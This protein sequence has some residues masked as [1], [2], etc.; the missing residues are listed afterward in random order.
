MVMGCIC[1]IIRFF[2][3]NFHIMLQFIFVLDGEY[4]TTIFIN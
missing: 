1:R 2:G 4:V 3:N